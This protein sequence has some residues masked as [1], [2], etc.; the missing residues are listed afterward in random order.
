MSLYN[1]I[2]DLQKLHQAWKKVH[3]NHPAAGVDHIT[4]EIFEKNLSDNLK[5]LNIELKNHKYNPLPVK[6]TVLYQGEKTREIAL[7]CVRDKVLQQSIATELNRIYNPLFARSTYAYR[8]DMSARLAIEEIEKKIQTKVYTH[9]MKI[10]ISHFF[11]TIQCII[12]HLSDG[13]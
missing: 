6:K 1:K 4:V 13:F 3:T 8:P 12:E 10:D 7:Y 5:Q 2:I 9:I 11:D